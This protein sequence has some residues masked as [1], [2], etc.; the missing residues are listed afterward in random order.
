[1]K[2]KTT[3]RDFKL[4]IKHCKYYLALY[5]LRNY[6]TSFE[7]D[8]LSKKGHPLMGGCSYSIDAKNAIIFLGKQWSEY[9]PV[10]DKHLENVAHHEV[11]ELFLGEFVK[12][13][14][15]RDFDEDHLDGV[16]HTIIQTLLNIHNNE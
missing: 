1:M 11:L 14:E 16:K 3:R 7:H 4:F 2:T 6:D 10:T 13:A 12:L 8:Y 5:N 15:A 9:D